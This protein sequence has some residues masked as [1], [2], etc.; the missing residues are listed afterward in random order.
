ME[1]LCLSYG[2]PCGTVVLEKGSTGSPSWLAL[3]QV[4]RIC[5]VKRVLMAM[6][7]TGD[8]PDQKYQLPMTGLFGCIYRPWLI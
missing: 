4:F 2:I 3:T 5:G 8:G 6:L 7:E 1:H